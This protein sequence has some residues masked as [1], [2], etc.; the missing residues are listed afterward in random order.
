MRRMGLSNHFINA[1]VGLTPADITPV[2]GSYYHRD[3]SV[4]NDEPAELINL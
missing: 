3:D 2:S 4:T 1:A